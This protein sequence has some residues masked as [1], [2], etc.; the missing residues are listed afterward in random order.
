MRPFGV[1]LL[2]AF[3]LGCESESA[4]LAADAAID[5]VTDTA[6]AD[7]ALAETFDA[8]VETG[9]LETGLGE[10]GLDGGDASDGAGDGLLADASD[11]PTCDPAT[12]CVGAPMPTWELEDFQPKSAGFKTKYGLSAFK[13]KVTVVALLAAW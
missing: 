1:A 11:A 9:F 12:T 7:S 4:P 5:A 8:L 10:T 6:R 13:P 2:F 3:A